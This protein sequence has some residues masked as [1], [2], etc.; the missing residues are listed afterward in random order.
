MLCAS[1]CVS[2]ALSR[3]TTGSATQSAER[4]DR[5]TAT[6]RA[7]TSVP[8]PAAVLD[9]VVPLPAGMLPLCRPQPANTLSGT[10]GNGQP[11]PRGM[12]AQMQAG[13]L[14]ALVLI[15]LVAHVG[16]VLARRV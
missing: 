8:A 4:L 12:S 2:A 14:L 16:G 13:T 9:Q 11:Q 10:W 6:N 5:R 15:L 7:R 1:A 3:L